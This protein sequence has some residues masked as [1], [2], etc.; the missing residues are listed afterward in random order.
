MAPS[1]AIRVNEKSTFLW[2]GTLKNENGVALGPSDLVTLICTL[3]DEDT[4]TIINSRNQ[5]NILNLNNFTL[6]TASSAN[7]SWD[8]PM[9]D[10]LIVDD[11]KETEVHIAKI[12]WT[13]GSGGAFGGKK[14]IAIRVV[15]LVRTT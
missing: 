9:A 1:F 14:E 12:E 13:F 5:Q 11:T 6:T 3:Y 8:S 10:Q 4:G 2:T 15:N 7:I